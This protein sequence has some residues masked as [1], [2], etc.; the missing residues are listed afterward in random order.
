MLSPATA[1]QLVEAFAHTLPSSPS[2]SPDSPESS[3]S[4]TFSPRMNEQPFEFST[5]AHEQY[6]QHD[7]DEYESLMAEGSGWDAAPR[8]GRW[9]ETTGAM[10]SGRP[11]S[12]GHPPTAPDPSSPSPLA[13][14]S[15]VSPRPV[16]GRNSS[17]Q[18][19]D[20]FRQVVAR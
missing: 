16:H 14:A 5:P 7:E 17:S 3:Y 2:D 15:A 19:L 18:I 13:A 20:D 4:S 12:Q 10:P 6:S 8:W 11:P 1:K 9:P